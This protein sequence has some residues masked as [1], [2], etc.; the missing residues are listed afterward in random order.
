MFLSAVF[1]IECAPVIEGRDST[2]IHGGEVLT[3]MFA[4]CLAGRDEFTII[5]VI[6]TISSEP[7]SVH[8]LTI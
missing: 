8:R 7:S 4:S 2:A 1:R 3:E 6:I 5:V